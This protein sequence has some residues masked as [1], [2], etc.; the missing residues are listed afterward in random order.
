VQNYSQRKKKTV[1][2]TY[3]G[4]DNRTV[5]VYKL[6]FR[7]TQATSETPVDIDMGVILVFVGALEVIRAYDMLT[8]E[9]NAA[10]SDAELSGMVGGGAPNALV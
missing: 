5:T 2:N 4:K 1:S 6:G 3:S 8:T 10:G 7:L 9:Q